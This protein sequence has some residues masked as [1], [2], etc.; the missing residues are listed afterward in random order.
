MNKYRFIVINEDG[1]V[2]GTD[3]E[4]L[5]EDFATEQDCVVLEVLEDGTVVERD[6]DFEQQE[7]PEAIQQ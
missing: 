3:N 5:A 2:Q 7:I 6:F 4:A 1:L